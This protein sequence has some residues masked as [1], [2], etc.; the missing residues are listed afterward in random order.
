MSVLFSG[1]SKNVS[2]LID[3]ILS[4]FKYG[5]G[6]YYYKFRIVLI[7]KKHMTLLYVNFK[8]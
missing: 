8:R 7:N 5:T 6:V 3:I 4:N 1:V 2:K